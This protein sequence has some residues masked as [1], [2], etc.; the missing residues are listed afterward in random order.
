MANILTLARIGLIAPLAAM[1]FI[2]AAYA[3]PAALAIFALAAVTDL[4][5]GMLARAEGR[6]TALGAA[7]DP[8]ADKMLIVAALVLLVRNGVI[9]DAGAIAALVI[10]LRE[11]FVGGMREAVSLKGATLPVT[12]LAK[13]KTATQLAAVGLLIATAPGGVGGDSLRP[14]AAAALWSA[15]VL[16]LWTGGAYALRAVAILQKG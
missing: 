10:I 11:I 16:T 8:L 3:M 12:G 14:L 1:F 4:F 15:A 7:L 2:D 6:V 5:D 13:I 9:R